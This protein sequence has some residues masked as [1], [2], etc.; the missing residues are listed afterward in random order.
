MA[1]LALNGEGEIAVAGRQMIGF[2]KK[3]PTSYHYFEACETVGDLLVAARSYGPATEYYNRLR[4]EA[5]WP[6]YRLRAS[7]AIGRALASRPRLILA[8]EPTGNLDE[9]TGDAV[10]DLMLALVA[11]TGAAL[12]MVTHS[13]HLAGRLDRRLHL[14]GGKLG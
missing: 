11:E 12:L 10:L 14:A 1:K 8:D 9:A 7:V 13:T 3:H 2:T 4:T 5:P 6:D